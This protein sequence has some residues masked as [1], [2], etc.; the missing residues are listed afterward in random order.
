MIGFD[1]GKVAALLE[2]PAAIVPVML[3]VLGHAAD[4][5]QPPR[6]YRRPLAEVV[7]LESFGGAAP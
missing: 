2:L 1:A 7:H 3:V 6:G 5:R 4:G